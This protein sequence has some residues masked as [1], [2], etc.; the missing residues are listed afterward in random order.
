[1]LIK[2]NF[3]KV[4]LAEIFVNSLVDRKLKAA[5]DEFLFDDFSN[6]DMNKNN[7]IVTV[8]VQLLK[9]EEILWRKYELQA[10]G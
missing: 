3:D 4:C 1:M 5:L 6:L 8:P 9:E 2:P 10:F 7:E